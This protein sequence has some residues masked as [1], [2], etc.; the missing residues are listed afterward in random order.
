VYQ[1]YV[2]TEIR[3][4]YASDVYVGNEEELSKAIFQSWMNSEP[5]REAML[6]SS[7][8]EMGLGVSI[9][10]EDKVFVALERC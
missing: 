10:R 3:R 1:G 6:V 9:T 4:E 5:H 8:D 7:A 2:D